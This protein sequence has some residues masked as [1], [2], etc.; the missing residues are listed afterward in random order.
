[1]EKYLLDGPGVDRREPPTNTS[2]KILWACMDYILQAY[3][4]VSGGSCENGKDPSGSTK[5]MEIL[6][7][8]GNI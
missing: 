2:S 8:L 5:F 1:M 7:W 6:D 4:K 3:D